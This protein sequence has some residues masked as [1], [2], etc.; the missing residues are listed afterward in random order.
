MGLLCLR[1][2]ANVSMRFFG[3]CQHISGMADIRGVLAS[4]DPIHTLDDL[5]LSAHHWVMGR[6][7]DRVPLLDGDN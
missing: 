1:C 5:T 3:I 2:D 4:I 6:E 7:R